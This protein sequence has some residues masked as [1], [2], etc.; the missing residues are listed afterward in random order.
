MKE[1]Y[2][3]KP[4]YRDFS[5]ICNGCG[6]QSW[7]PTTIDKPYPFECAFCR[8]VM[9]MVDRATQRVIYGHSK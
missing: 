1:D 9:P 6:A 5:M 3:G 7:Q 2:T 4:E 8:R